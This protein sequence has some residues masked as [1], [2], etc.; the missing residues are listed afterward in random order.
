MLADDLEDTPAALKEAAVMATQEPQV[1][2]ALAVWFQ[3][4]RC[5]DVHMTMLWV[6]LRYSL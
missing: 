6:L 1:G 5:I 2:T 3:L 4:Q